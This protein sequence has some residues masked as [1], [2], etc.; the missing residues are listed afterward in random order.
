MFE[1]TYA[2]HAHIA[3]ITGTG[4]WWG[5]AGRLHHRSATPR[6]RSSAGTR[7]DRVPVQPEQ[8]DRD[9]RAATTVEAVLDAPRS[10][11][12]RRGVRRV[13]AASAR[14]TRRDDGRLVVTRTYSKMWSMAALRLGFAVGAA[15]GRRGAREGGAAVPPRRRPP[16]SRAGSRWSSGPRWTIGCTAGRGT[17]AGRRGPRRGRRHHVF[18]SGANF[19]LFRPARRRSRALGGAGRAGRAGPRLL[20]A[21]RAST[22]ACA[23]PSARPT[24]N[25]TFLAALRA[26]LQEV[27]RLMREHARR[28]QPSTRATKETTIELVARPRRHGSASR[29]PASRSSTTCSSSSASTAASTCGSS[30]PVISRS[31]STT[32]WRTS[33]SCSARRCRRPSATRPACG[34]SRPRSCPLDEALVQV[35]LD[36]SGRPFLV[37]EVDPVAEWIGTFDPQLAEEFW[38]AFAFARRHHA[39]HP[40]AL[41]AQRAPRDRGVVQG[42]RPGTPRRG[43]VE[44]SGVPSTKGTL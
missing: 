29:R 34:G 31:I 19:M 9:G 44:G 33:A 38:R 25:D 43:K 8:P 42:R 28:D 11:R 20:A 4:W 23:S 2:L 41:G 14:S 22:T 40:F 30:R 16:R 1:P 21:G 6:G 7:P 24:E 26:S 37:Y 5:S 12:R 15:V 39:A 35:A 27:A 13:R 10:G 3:R 18:P 32:P 17:R 36:L